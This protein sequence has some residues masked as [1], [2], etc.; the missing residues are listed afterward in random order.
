MRSGLPQVSSTIFSIEASFECRTRK[1]AQPPVIFFRA[2][3]RFALRKQ[4]TW[5]VQP[6]S[7]IFE[8]TKGVIIKRNCPLGPTTTSGQSGQS[9]NTV[10]HEGRERIRRKNSAHISLGNSSRPVRTTTLFFVFSG[11]LLAGCASDRSS[12]KHPSKTS[13]FDSPD[14]GSLH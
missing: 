4:G 12:E 13:F 6:R 5:A 8:L 11:L 3:S 14:V 10:H 9:G 7:D 1:S 2:P